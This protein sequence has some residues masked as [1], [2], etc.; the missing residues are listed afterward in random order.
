M[1]AEVPDPTALFATEYE[2]PQ[3]DSSPQTPT[4]EQHDMMLGGFDEYKPSALINNESEEDYI[5]EDDLLAHDPAPSGR[6]SIS[7]FPASIIHHDVTPMQP[8][9]RG[10]LHTPSRSRAGTPT[11]YDSMVK[12]LSPHSSRE[13]VTGFRNPSSIRALQMRDEFSDNEDLTP[14]HRR[15]G[16]RMSYV[17]YRSGSTHST[18]GKRLSRSLQSSPVKGTK[19]RKEFPLVLLHCSLLPGLVSP[20]AKMIGEDMLEAII[21]EPYKKRWK[22]LQEKVVKN[23]EVR[24]RGVLIPHPKED[25]E[26]LEEKLLESL[27]LELPRI[28]NGHF[29]ARS[30]SR[31]ST[32]DS[33]FGS[34]EASSWG[35]SEAHQ[36]QEKCVDCGSKLC[37]EKRWEVKVYAANGLMRAGA[38]SAAWSEMEK[39]DVEVSVWLPEEVRLEVETRL[40]AV[41]AQEQQMREDETRDE[42]ETPVDPRRRE[43]YGEPRRQ[44]EIDG[45]ADVRQSSDNLSRSHQEVPQR[46]TPTDQSSFDRSPAKVD[47]PDALYN[48]ARL[49]ARDGRNI[50]IFLLSVLVI[51]YA[52]ANQDK[53][54]VSPANET[55]IKSAVENSPE[56]KIEYQYLTTTVISTSISIETTLQTNTITETT[57]VS[58]NSAGSTSI[59]EGI[60]AEISV[61]TSD[62]SL[63]ETYELTD[64]IIS[65]PENRS[66]TDM[67]LL[68]P[69]PTIEHA[70]SK[71]TPDHQLSDHQPISLSESELP[72]NA[73]I[74]DQ[75][76][77]DL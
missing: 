56:T 14:G 46:G 34:E 53:S 31:A 15:R 76:R 72:P 26:T 63:N 6:S 58:V 39:V 50:A 35:E 21:P 48:Y 30:E 2:S 16:S 32:A 71:S 66:L 12:P 19:L 18:P 36:D 33:G 68:T 64:Q 42:A 11:L 22:T 67:G 54:S 60:P 5:T 51:F 20:K 74:Q 57:S 37:G 38:W 23:S 3:S 8:Y 24:N 44:D 1:E 61:S 69:S 13:Y 75:F 28:S 27:E 40:E 43:I 4:D 49:L 59:P 62:S 17:S 77:E 70:E 41:I 7:S 47:L 65:S 45:L 29:V 25:Y 10:G 73:L 52:M 9:H 55:V